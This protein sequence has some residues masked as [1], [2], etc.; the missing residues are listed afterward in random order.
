MTHIKTIALCLIFMMTTPFA[1]A[2]LC[3]ETRYC[4]E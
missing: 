4:Y 2:D 1:Y 3:V